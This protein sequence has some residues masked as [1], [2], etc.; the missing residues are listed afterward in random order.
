[1]TT[2]EGVLDA[3]AKLKDSLNKLQ[4]VCR[5]L[6]SDDADALAKQVMTSP[7]I[8]GMLDAMKIMAPKG[9]HVSVT[10]VIE[11]MSDTFKIGMTVGIQAAG[12]ALAE[13]IQSMAK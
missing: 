5:G 8:Q 11:L 12:L 6:A 13:A 10:D 9:E 1:M 2:D 3:D 4:L 7:R